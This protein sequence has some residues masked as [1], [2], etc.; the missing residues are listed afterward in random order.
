[1][2]TLHRRIYVVDVKVFKMFTMKT[3]F[4]KRLKVGMYQIPSRM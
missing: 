2:K 3:V 1:M 4:T